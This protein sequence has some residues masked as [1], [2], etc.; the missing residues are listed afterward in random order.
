M[1]YLFTHNKFFSVAILCSILAVFVVSITGWK[2][3]KWSFEIQSI[4]RTKASNELLIDNF[5]KQLNLYKGG[6]DEKAN[7]LFTVRPKQDELVP[8]LN[9]MERIAGKASARNFALQ[10]IPFNKTDAPSEN[11]KALRYRA[12]FQATPAIFKAFLEEFEEAPY[13]LEIIE[14]S[15]QKDDTLGN[16][17]LGNISI[18]FYIFIR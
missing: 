14:T 18:T 16:F 1:F 17:E 7:A 15:F 3:N 5:E 6:F 13:Y 8:F 11:S 10:S 2:I 12:T 4:R 9:N